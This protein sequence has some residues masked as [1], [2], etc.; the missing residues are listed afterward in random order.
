M[1]GAELDEQLDELGFSLGSVCEAIITTLDPKGSPSASPMGVIRI[2]PKTIEIMPFKTSS[3][4]NNLLAHPR[5]CINITCDPALYLITAF[6]HET[7]EGF[8]KPVVYD[9]LR[10]KSSDAHV[11][12]DVQESSDVSEIRSSFKCGVDS[13][14]VVK[15]TP[16]VFSRGRAETI[17]AIIHATRIEVFSREGKC[18]QVER[19]I[20]RFYACKHIVGRVSSLGST[21]ARV[22]QEL[23][24]LIGSWRKR[25]WR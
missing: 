9:D 11:F 20:S 18:E 14:E 16:R 12:V 23:E 13:I 21:E 3:T 17:E 22:I 15:P 1:K 4:Y 19:L 5:A 7:F 10:L 24:R 8:G 25:S 6:K 2:G